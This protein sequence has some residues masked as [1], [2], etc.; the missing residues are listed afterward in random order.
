MKTDITKFYCDRCGA[1]IENYDDRG[2]VV[3]YWTDISLL[4]WI[5]AFGFME[6]NRVKMDL[7]QI[8]KTML[9]GYLTPRGH[10]KK[11]NDKGEK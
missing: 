11:L 7:C 8:C 9:I 2:S 4:D 3:V 1:E 6:K 10:S 5:K